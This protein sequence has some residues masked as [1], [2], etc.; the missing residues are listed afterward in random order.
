MDLKK[1]LDSLAHL[2]K[3]KTL[4]TLEKCSVILYKL[5]FMAS[6]MVVTMPPRSWPVPTTCLEIKTG[7]ERTIP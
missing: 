2:Q 7:G 3:L 6:L 5:F 1:A 4:T